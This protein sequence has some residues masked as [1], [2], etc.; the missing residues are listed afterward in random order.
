MESKLLKAHET[1]LKQLVGDSESR[2]LS[3]E[4]ITTLVWDKKTKTLQSKV[5]KVPSIQL[6]EKGVAASPASPTSPL[7]LRE[8]PVHFD[9]GDETG[10]SIITCL[11]KCC[12]NNAIATTW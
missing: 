10:T 4:G 8:L 2:R 7:G 5:V 6:N 9:G 3:K 11:S 12:I 1:T